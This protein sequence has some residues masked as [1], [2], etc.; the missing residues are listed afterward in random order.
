MNNFKILIFLIFTI[1]L[2]SCNTKELNKLRQENEE[3]KTKIE[4][5]E[6]EN[7]KLKEEEIK[8][9]ISSIPQKI[10]NSKNISDA[11]KM[12][13]DIKTKYA[14]FPEIE[15]IITKEKQKLKE[16]TTRQN[17]KKKNVKKLYPIDR[18][19]I[20]GNDVRM[21][22]AMNENYIYILFPEIRAFEGKGFLFELGD[23]QT[24]IVSTD[25]WTGDMLYELWATDEVIKKCKDAIA[26][27]KAYYY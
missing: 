24:K 23:W 3:L 16:E 9:I 7:E 10:K 5:L 8:R 2:V 1:F 17:A 13:D 4:I 11:E 14:S 25:Q 12:L 6:K 27:A 18:R 15:Q 21:Y 22:L 20:S 26:V 19:F